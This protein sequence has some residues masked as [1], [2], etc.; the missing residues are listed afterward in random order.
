MSKYIESTVRTNRLWC[1]DC[2]DKINKGDN[3]IFHLSESRR[4]EEV[5]CESC[6]T[7]YMIEA[8]HDSVHPFSDEAF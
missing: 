8:Y 7:D 3:V 2:G 6:K 1:S 4:M 5:F